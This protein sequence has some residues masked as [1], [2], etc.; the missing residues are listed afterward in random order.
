MADTS[1]PLQRKRLADQVADRLMSMIAEGV[2]KPGDRLPPEPEL[3]KQFQVG[4]SSIR[5]AV[6]AL[7]LIGLV[8]V[9]PGQGTHV[10]PFSTDDHRRP[11]GLLG[12]GRD[13]IRELVEA[14]L[15]LECTIVRLAA[16]R[17]TTEDLETIKEAH[18]ALRV[19]LENGESPINQ[20]LAF[21]LAV[22]GACHNSVLIRFLREM[23]Q[24]IRS[25]MEQKARH[26][27]GYDQVFEQHETI[28]EAIASG[29]GSAA[30]QALKSHLLATSERLVTAILADG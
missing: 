16:E 3:M 5:E 7:S 19:T 28:I 29:S 26:S 25:W 8:T 22:A 13:R 21:H 18:R 4:R 30:E 17:A 6:G 20:D 24:P 1:A 14:R 15:E 23:R 9:R 2:W 12:I 11:V 10:A 27:W